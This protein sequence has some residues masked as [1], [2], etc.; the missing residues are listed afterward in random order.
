[1]GGLFWQAALFHVQLVL[2]FSRPVPA[3]FSSYWKTVL[4]LSF[5]HGEFNCRKRESSTVFQYGWPQPAS[6]TGTSSIGTHAV[7]FM[8]RIVFMY[9]LPI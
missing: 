1:M 2:N 3:K 7:A 4:L 9:L 6:H 5:R 8:Y